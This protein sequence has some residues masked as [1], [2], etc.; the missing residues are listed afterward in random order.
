MTVATLD[1]LMGAVGKSGRVLWAFSEFYL[2]FYGI[3][4]AFIFQHFPVFG[5]ISVAIYCVDESLEAG[6]A[7]RGGI[8]VDELAHALH[9]RIKFNDHIVVLLEEAREY[10]ACEDAARRDHG[11][12]DLK[13][14]L[15]VTQIR[16]VDFRLMHHALLQI[17]GIPHDEDVFGWFRAFEMLMEIEDDLSSVEE[18][19]QKGGYN[20][21]CFVRRLVG[22]QNAAMLVERQR[23]DLEAELAGRGTALSDRGIGS[24]RAVLD[25][26]REI[27]PWRPVLDGS[28]GA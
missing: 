13:D 9:K 24:W 26:Y 3:E 7:K 15:R 16:S 17:K 19:E 22:A 8:G 11:M 20:Y 21:F 4:P 6:D 28:D 2:R 10:C 12:S 23:A 27:V 14:I 1:L 18:D 25:R 5:C